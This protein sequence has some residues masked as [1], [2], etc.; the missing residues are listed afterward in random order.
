MKLYCPRCSASSD[1]IKKSGHYFRKSD[2]KT[3]QRF[4]CTKCKKHFSKATFLPNYRQNKRRLNSMIYK[5]FCG[6]VSQRRMAKFL[7]CNRKTIARKLKVLAHQARLN[8]EEW[9]EGQKFDHIFIDDLE[10]IEHSKL[11]PVTV[12]VVVNSKRQIIDF[13]VARIPAKGHLVKPSHKKY[14]KRKN[15]A[16]YERE[17]LFC[18]LIGITKKDVLIQSDKHPHYQELIKKYFP[19]AFH[20]T[21]KGDRSSLYGNGELKRAK[22]DPLF[23]INHTLAM[24]RDGLSRLVRK[25]WCTTKC[26]EA[27]NDHIAIY[28]DYHNRELVNE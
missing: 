7:N 19:E 22:Y 28:V 16:I 17:R 2:S 20:F 5:L 4:Q 13:R 12:T 23:K 21:T 8:H 6:K 26:I 9:L 11:K 3:I 27:L 18:D 1:F 14:G 10:T 25:T 24:M 15:E